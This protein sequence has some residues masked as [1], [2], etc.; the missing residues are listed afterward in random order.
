ML[1]MVAVVPELV[2]VIVPVAPE[3]VKFDE[4]VSKL[5]PEP[6][7]IYVDVRV[8]A[9]A[10]GVAQVLSPLK[11]VVAEAVPVADKS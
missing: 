2:S 4:P 11:K 8:A 9:P 7:P 6:Y 5:P 3:K 1:C 10:A